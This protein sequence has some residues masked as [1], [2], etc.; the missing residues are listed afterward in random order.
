MTIKEEFEGWLVER[1]HEHIEFKEAKGQFDS[2]RL[3]QYCVALANERG[4]KLILG[5]SNRH[6]RAVVGTLAFQ[7]I[8]KTKKGLLDSLHVR[9]NVHE[10]HFDGKRVIIFD[11]A[12]RPVGTPIG[13]K[14][15]YWMRVG[16][17]LVPMTPEVLKR[18]F[19]ETE[20][21]FSAEPCEKA[22]LDDLDSVAIASMQT[23]WHKKSL[24]KEILQLTTE[25]LLEATE[26]VVH[27]KITYAALVLLG[28]RESLGKYL[29]NAEIV[30]E[31]RTVETSI[32]SDTR[33]D[34]RSG[35][36]ALQDDLWQTIN[37]R[38]DVQHIQ[39]GL[40][41][42]DISNFNEEV[43]REALLNAVCHRD[44]QLS[45]SVFV[46]HSPKSLEIESPGP[47]PAG[48]TPENILDRQVPRNRRIAEVFQKCGL[49]ERSGQGADKM[50]R[51]SLEEAK[52]RPD[53]GKSDPFTVNLKLRADIQDIQ[54]LRF[55]ERLSEEREIR[56][57]LADLL[58]LDDLRQG[59]RPHASAHDTLHRLR[60]QQVIE[61]V[62]R[63]RGTKH[64]LSK[65]FY[66]FVGEKGTYTRRK[67]LDR[68]EKKSLILRHLQ[69]Y[70]KGFIKDF[71]QAI[72]SLSRGQIHTL[73]KLLKKEEKIEYIGHKR[74]GFWRLRQSR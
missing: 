53:Y 17:S 73:L 30:Y 4:G 65:R 6:P 24:N 14:G 43:V 25:Q 45:G 42:R 22:H 26:L 59:K 68:E 57:S 54:F 50:F 46:R 61:V 51:R 35:F 37:Q 34:F 66:T 28:K 67:G 60:D 1:E 5:V 52:P 23:L 21:D 7:N 36:F 41:V 39:E 2:E 19:A 44:Y 11:V 16:E 18:V 71:E 49:V 55:L 63:G 31:F 8:D 74:R 3:K 62:G 12:S 20:P 9:V 48:V 13:Y 40:F 58:L 72:P 27:G 33:K 15:A 47:F 56:W 38:N 29:A 32:P 10:V 64:I 70:P 69:E